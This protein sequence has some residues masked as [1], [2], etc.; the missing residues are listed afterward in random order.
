MG[1]ATVKFAKAVEAGIY[2][3]QLGGEARSDG[4]AN[5]FLYLLRADWLPM[6]GKGAITVALRKHTKEWDLV[7][8]SGCNTSC[9]GQRDAACGGVDPCST[10]DST[11][12]KVQYVQYILCIQCM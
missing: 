3:A 2:E 7:G 10:G 8:S 6:R 4:G 5:G 11:N 12:S 9:V 1:Q